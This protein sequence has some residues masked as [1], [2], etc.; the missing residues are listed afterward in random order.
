M[1]NKRITLLSDAEIKSLY[2]RPGFTHEEREF[3]FSLSDADHLAIEKYHNKKTSSI[4][5]YSSDILEQENS[6]MIFLLKKLM[7]I[8]IMLLQLILMAH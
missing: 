7:K 3:F 8:S 4:L 6:F 1:R 2:S 5:S